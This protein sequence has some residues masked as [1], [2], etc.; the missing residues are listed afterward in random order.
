MLSLAGV[1]VAPTF[2]ARGDR[3]TVEPVTGKPAADVEPLADLEALD[4][5]HRDSAA[6]PAEYDPPGGPEVAG[7]DARKP[8]GAKPLAGELDRE[9][10]IGLAAV[11][12]APVE[13]GNLQACRAQIDRARGR[14]RAVGGD[15]VRGGEPDRPGEHRRE[16][17]T[18]PAAVGLAQPCADVI[19]PAERAGIVE[20]LAPVYFRRDARDA[21]QAP[22]M[23]PLA[24]DPARESTLVKVAAEKRTRR[25]KPFEPGRGADLDIGEAERGDRGK[26]GENPNR[27]LAGDARGIQAEPGGIAEARMVDDLQRAAD[28]A[29][30]GRLDGQYRRARGQAGDLDPAALE[31]ELAQ[32]AALHDDHDSVGV[33]LDRGFD[34]DDRP[35]RPQ[36]VDPRTGQGERDPG[37][38]QSGCGRS[39]RHAD[40]ELGLEVADPAAVEVRGDPGP[41]AGGNALGPVPGEVLQAQALEARVPRCEG[42][43]ADAGDTALERQKRPADIDFQPIDDE[44]CP[45]GLVRPC[46]AR[47]VDV[48]SVGPERPMGHRARPAGNFETSGFQ[49]A[50]GVDPRAHRAL[51]RQ[52]NTAQG[53]HRGD[54]ALDRGGEAIGP[55]RAELGHDVERPG[56]AVA[57]CGAA[58][59]CP[60]LA[61]PRFQ[62][63]H[64]VKPVLVS[65]YRDRGARCG[66]FEAEQA[67][68]QTQA[69]TMNADPAQRRPR[70]RLP[71]SAQQ[72][73]WIERQGRSVRARQAERHRAVDVADHDHAR[74]DQ[75]EP[76]RC[77]PAG[78][79]GAEGEAHRD[80]GYDRQYPAPG[81]AH[82]GLDRQYL[83]RPPP[84]APAQHD[85]ANPDGV[86]GLDPGE[87]LIDIRLG[88]AERDRAVGQP[89]GADP[90]E[91]DHRKP[92]DQEKIDADMAQTADHRGGRSA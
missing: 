31:L 29:A 6:V 76:G 64:G 15:A 59:D 68:V 67:V 9:C 7:G 86:G 75:V 84:A 11:R 28:R 65:G 32:E 27:G 12:L 66:P 17:Q 24:V 47:A 3:P 20:P 19:A 25:R 44:P 16:V 79:Q 81:I 8:D 74:A 91:H 85:I 45:G 40:R 71:A 54:R 60:G 78:H 38:L 77:D 39:G 92:A 49:R 89:P 55:H 56:G 53:R 13:L 14:A 1:S 61:N 51:Q 80:L 48:E 83:H 90:G 30:Q 33:D 23:H 63:E 34:T 21:R 42:V 70:A 50:L 46:H 57:A 4:I 26:L 18:E 73:G 58:E 36:V 10:G 69:C 2:H 37:A 72:A 87:C 62:V 88:E 5:D 35:Q 43:G 22:H 41:R 52:R 82:A